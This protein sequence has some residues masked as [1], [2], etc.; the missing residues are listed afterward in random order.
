L[1]ATDQWLDLRLTDVFENGVQKWFLRCLF[2]L[3]AAK[4]LDLA[5]DDFCGV[6]LEVLEEKIGED[7][8]FAY[9]FYGLNLL[10]TVLEP[11]FLCL[12]LRVIVVCEVII[13]VFFELFLQIYQGFL[14]HHLDLAG[15]A[16]IEHALPLL[17]LCG[18]AVFRIRLVFAIWWLIYF[19]L[20]IVIFVFEVHCF[21][22]FV[23]SSRRAR[24]FVL[25]V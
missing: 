21:F 13:Q 1:L 7:I 8:I 18:E 3:G 17:R 4:L 2:C 10:G 12:G 9:L 14:A 23:F 16:L 25:D 24:Q 6:S 19:V 20:V 11:F 22:V 5:S 15:Y